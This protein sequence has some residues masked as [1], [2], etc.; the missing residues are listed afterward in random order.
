MLAYTEV[1]FTAVVNL[2]PIFSGQAL[3]PGL[4]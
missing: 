3:E 4:K 1:L 2:I